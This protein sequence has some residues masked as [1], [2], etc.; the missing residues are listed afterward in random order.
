MKL[1][2]AIFQFCQ[3]G[4]GINAPKLHPEYVDF[5]EHSRGKGFH[6]NVIAGFSL[7]HGFEFEGMVVVGKADARFGGE[8]R[9]AV[10]S[11]RSFFVGFKILAVFVVKIRDDQISQFMFAGGFENLGKFAFL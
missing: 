2:N 3:L 8:F 7:G 5:E 4:N 9:S 1:R 10:E 6:E 11:L